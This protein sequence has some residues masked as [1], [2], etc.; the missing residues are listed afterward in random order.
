[1]MGYAARLNPKSKWNRSRNSDQQQEVRVL[2]P[3]Q[4]E[5]VV[6]ELSLKNLWGFLCHRLTQKNNPPQSHALT[7]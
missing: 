2:T 4:G 3:S 7:S 6:I 5:P 1:M